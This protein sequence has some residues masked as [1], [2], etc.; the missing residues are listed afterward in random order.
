VK[1]LALDVGEK[2]IGIASTDELGLEIWPQKAFLRRNNNADFEKLA[3]QIKDSA[4][5]LLVVGIPYSMDGSKGSAYQK[6]KNFI[7]K[8]EGFLEKENFQIPIK[9]CDERLS[10]WEAEQRLLEHGFKGENKKKRVDSIA[11][12]II[13][14]DFLSQKKY[15]NKD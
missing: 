3:Q 5:Q 9:T 1:I 6:V 2:R 10:S 8:L 4:A 7:K 11:A 13:L 12:C 15:E 14:E